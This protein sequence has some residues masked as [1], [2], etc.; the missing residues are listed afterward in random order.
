[1]QQ[2]PQQ[3]PTFT[4]LMNALLA[5]IE[6]AQKKGAYNLQESSAIFQTIQLINANPDV[7]AL[8]VKDKQAEPKTEEKVEEM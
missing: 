8:L 6:T 1:M 4:Q 2:Q 5:A 7:Q 3:P